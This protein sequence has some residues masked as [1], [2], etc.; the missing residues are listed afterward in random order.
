MNAI[1]V[2]VMAVAAWVLARQF[3][4]L[5]KHE[6]EVAP[7]RDLPSKFHPIHAR[8]DVLEVFRIDHKA[9]SDQIAATLNAINAQMAAQSE[10]Q[11]AAAQRLKRIEDKIDSQ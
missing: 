8:I 4:T 10:K 1:L 9:Q 6:A 5:E 7:L 3:V 11:D 2:V